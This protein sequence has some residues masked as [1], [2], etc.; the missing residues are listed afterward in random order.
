MDPEA[1]W[2]A[3]Y[4]LS[5]VMVREYEAALASLDQAQ[6]SKSQSGQSHNN[7][8]KKPGPLKGT[9]PI[10]AFLVSERGQSL[11]VRGQ[12]GLVSLVG[13]KQHL[14]D[15][16]KIVALADHH[17][18]VLASNK[19]K[20]PAVDAWRPGT[21]DRSIMSSADPEIDAVFSAVS[22]A[23]A[24]LGLKTYW[25]EAEKHFVAADLTCVVAPHEVSEAATYFHNFLQ[26]SGSEHS[27]SPART[28]AKYAT[29]EPSKIRC[30]ALRLA[31]WPQFSE[32]EHLAL[33][34]AL[35]QSQGPYAK[36][37]ALS[38]LTAQRLIETIRYPEALAIML[39]LADQDPSFRLS[40]ELLQRIFSAKQK[41]RGAV[42]LQGL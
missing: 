4:L 32:V 27:T 9:P 12:F 22:S 33:L 11:W 42:A 29:W 39:D 34:M 3:S 25:P 26:E 31:T 17:T 14:S 19:V 8:T 21:T 30:L 5:T 16:P 10:E 28:L 20:V 24:P 1:A 36:D 7:K 6:E 23:L 13:R 18:K 15:L 2:A 37:M 41:G 40:Y 35:R 38:A